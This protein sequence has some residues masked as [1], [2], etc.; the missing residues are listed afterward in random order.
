MKSLAFC[1]AGWLASF[2]YDFESVRVLANSSLK[3]ADTHGIEYWNVHSSI[4]KH[5]EEVMSG[6]QD[7][8]TDLIEHQIK[9][10]RTTGAEL[11]RGSF[12]FLL[13]ECYFIKENMSAA[14]TC[15][16]QAL[17]KVDI[18]EENWW[19][20]ELLRLKGDVLLKQH[21]REQSISKE[22]VG[23]IKMLYTEA[24]QTARQQSAKSLELR[25]KM[26]LLHLCSKMEN[27][28]DVKQ[29]LAETYNCFTEGFDTHDL[30]KARLMLDTAHV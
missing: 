1:F 24:I 21:E 5:W 22:A 27:K 2:F 4:L 26:G 6:R 30:K 23:T 11:I 9:V 16:D 10:H 12:L 28:Q 8:A 15:I 17:E 7:D 18:I 20:A 13:A 29:S 25:A 19:K 3:L 14:L